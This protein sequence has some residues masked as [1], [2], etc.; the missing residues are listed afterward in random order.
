MMRQNERQ[1][2]IEYLPT[3]ILMTIMAVTVFTVL[4]NGVKIYRDVEN[5]G[6]KTYEDLAVEQYLITKIRQAEDGSCIQAKQDDKTS[7]V[8]ISETHDGV[9]YYTQ[10]YENEGF[11]TEIFAQKGTDLM[12]ENGEQILPLDKVFFNKEKNNLLE[13]KIDQS[14]GN[15]RLIFVS[16]RGE[17]DANEK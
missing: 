17:D 15:N 11:L 4:I 7:S 1:H 14:S 9:E 12:P 3:I 2:H 13:I 16:L 5:T 10:I 6:R 8:I